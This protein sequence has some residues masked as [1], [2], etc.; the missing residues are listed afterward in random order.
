MLDGWELPLYMIISSLSEVY[1]VNLKY[2]CKYGI[3]IDI[4]DSYQIKSEKNTD[5]AAETGTHAKL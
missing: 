2:K 5:L 3:A 4:S 1:R